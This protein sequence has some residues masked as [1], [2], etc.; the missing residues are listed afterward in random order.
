MSLVVLFSALVINFSI[1]RLMPGNPIDTFTSGAKLTVEARQAV[2]A[3]F[4]LDAPLWDQFWRY[5][6]NSIRADFGLSF[7]YF[8]RP[9]IDVMLDALPWTF[10]ILMT[11]LVLQVAIGYFLGVTAAW[12]IGTSVDSTLQTASLAILSVPVFWLGMVLLYYFGFELSWFPISGAYTAG[13]QYDSAYDFIKDVAS[14]AALPIVALTIARYGSFQLILRNTMVTV[15]RKQYVLTAEA[16]GLSEN[17]VKFRHA[18]RNALLPMVTFVGLS[19]AFS[20]AGS[21][22]VETIFSYPGVGKLMYAAV[23][24]RDYP[25]LQGGFFMFSL[26]AIAMNFVVDIAYMFLDPRIRY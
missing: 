2:I 9:V 18:A 5:L 11:S 4:G 25:L 10:L 14:H 1:P 24:A 26:V 20:V 12:K 17:A 6:S 16:K 22:F 8:P 3:R 23:L 13:A 15:L 21:V 19:F 7:T